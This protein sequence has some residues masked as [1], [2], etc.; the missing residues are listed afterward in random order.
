MISVVALSEM[1]SNRLCS[2]D[3]NCSATH[4]K[5]RQPIGPMC[6]KVGSPSRA[7]PYVDPLASS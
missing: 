2:G 4:H 1:N 7:S 5:K 3:M 6:S